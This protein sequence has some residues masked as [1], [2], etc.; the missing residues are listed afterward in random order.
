MEFSWKQNK[1][2]HEEIQPTKSK[3]KVNNL[4]VR[5]TQC[6]GPDNNDWIY[7]N[8]GTEAKQLWDFITENDI[9]ATNPDIKL[10]NTDQ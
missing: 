1:T 3:T 5:K 8:K 10:S 7:I 9:D 2:N 4:G 6:Y